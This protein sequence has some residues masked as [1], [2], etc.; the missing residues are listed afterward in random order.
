MKIIS[1]CSA[2]ILFAAILFLAGSCN[3]ASTPTAC[4]NPLPDTAYVYQA[5]VFK[6]C[7]A[8]AA[9]YH[10]N[11]GDGNSATGDSAVHSYTA[12]GVYHG[13][14][15]ASNSSSKSFTIVVV[16]NPGGYF[17]I[18]SQ[19]YLP[20]AYSNT[21]Q[22]T[23]IFQVNAEYVKDSSIIWGLTCAFS[24]S[25]PITTGYYNIVQPYA[26]LILPGD[27]GIDFTIVNGNIQHI[28][29]TN[30]TNKV[31]VTVLP[32]GKLNIVGSAVELY[33]LNNQSDSTSL[34]FNITQVP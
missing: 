3:K 1:F 29:G 34:T 6:S 13:S 16:V 33:N 11:F 12:S 32:N 20:N 30:T 8:G 19:H 23:N 2:A 24:N 22:A 31:F 21:T 25:V 10:W 7:T 28:S 27:V 5:L 15:T 18:N 26:A 17:M 9:T 14:L 4:I